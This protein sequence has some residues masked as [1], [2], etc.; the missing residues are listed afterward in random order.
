MGTRASRKRIR[1]CQVPRIPHLDRF[2]WKMSTP[3][4]SGVQTSAVTFCLP[5]GIVC[6][7]ITVKIAESAPLVAHFF[8]PLRM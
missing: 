8:S 5:S 7:A 2:F 3:G 4:M 1:A 6:R